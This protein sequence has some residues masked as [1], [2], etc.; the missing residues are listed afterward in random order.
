VS[1]VLADEIAQQGGRLL[2]WRQ[3]EEGE[4]RPQGVLRLLL[5]SGPDEPRGIEQ[6]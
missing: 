4:G 3:G 6:I 5:P 2:A 1:D